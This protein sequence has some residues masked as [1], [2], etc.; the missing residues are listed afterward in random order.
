MRITELTAG[1]RGYRDEMARLGAATA[2]YIPTTLQ[3]NAQE[4]N[5]RSAPRPCEHILTAQ[6]RSCPTVAGRENAANRLGRKERAEAASLQ[7]GVTAPMP[8]SLLASVAVVREMAVRLSRA[9]KGMSWTSGV[10]VA[11]DEVGEEADLHLSFG[12]FR[13]LKIPCPTR[14]PRFPKA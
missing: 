7:D 2:P 5:A 10:C 6:S 11:D 14:E 8:T 3:R 12:W 4:R 1:T 13:L 9:T